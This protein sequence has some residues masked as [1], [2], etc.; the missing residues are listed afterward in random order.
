MGRFP[1]RNTSASWRSP[2]AEKKRVEGLPD[3]DTCVIRIS[4]ARGA[5]LRAEPVLMK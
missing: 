5:D 2:S 1:G 3:P 4:V